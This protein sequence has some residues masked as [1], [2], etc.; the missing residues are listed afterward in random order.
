MLKGFKE[1][2]LRSDLVTVAVGLVMALA[3]FTLIEALV[4]HLIAPLIALIF[5][6]AN[7]DAIT[8]RI[9]TTEFGGGAVIETALTFVLTLTAVC[10]LVVAPY[11]RFQGRR[12]VTTKT[13]FCPE[14]TSSIPVAA[15]RC[16]YCTAIVQPDSA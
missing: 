3:T 14:C 16:R 9:S 5:G 8:F 15:K 11:R 10:F 4:A 12:G 1:F 2:M 7:V 13:R 6:K